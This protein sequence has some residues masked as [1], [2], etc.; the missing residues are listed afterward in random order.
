MDGQKLRFMELEHY[1]GGVI[2]ES[3][4]GLMAMISPRDTMESAIEKR[5][6]ILHHSPA[7]SLKAGANTTRDGT[8]DGLGKQQ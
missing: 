7:A 4:A 1:L 8:N 2:K 6:G 5:R 3:T